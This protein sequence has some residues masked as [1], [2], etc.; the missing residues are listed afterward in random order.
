MVSNRLVKHK[1]IIN[2]RQVGRRL[3]STWWFRNS[4]SSYFMAKLSGRNL[5]FSASGLQKNK[6]RVVKGQH[7]LFK[8]HNGHALILLVF[9]WWDFSHRETYKCRWNGKYNLCAQKEE[10]MDFVSMD[11]SFCCKYLKTICLLVFCCWF[12]IFFMY[13]QVCLFRVLFY[14]P[15]VYLPIL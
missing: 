7:F 15:F 8:V 5:S 12:A 2:C 3:F 9:H 1:H 11:S 13:T 14:V 10:E 6:E 4:I